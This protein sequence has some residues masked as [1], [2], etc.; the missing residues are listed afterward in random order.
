MTS[1]LPT[2]V[3]F[4]DEY[5]RPVFQMGPFDAAALAE[6]FEIIRSRTDPLSLDWETWFGPAGVFTMT[7]NGR[8]AIDLTLEDLDLAPD[9][10]IL[11]VTTSGGPYVSRCVTDSIARRCR[12]SR[13]LGP[14]TRAIFMI[15]E[16]G[17]P[18]AL[19]A[20]LVDSGLPII[21][22]CAY[23]FGSTAPEGPTGRL[24]DYVIFSFSKSMPL[25]YGGL[26]KSRHRLR[27]GSTLSGR[28]QRETPILLEHHLA[29]IPAAVERRRA[30]YELYRERF[31]EEG[32]RPLFDLKPGVAPHSFLVFLPDEA[33]AAAMRPRLHGAGVI[34]SV[35]YGGG[36]YF[37]PNHQRLSEAAVDYIVTHFVAALREC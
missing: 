30:V 29:A 4:A 2:E 1:L 28:A 33:K 17:F 11:I 9:D 36:G 16:F 20:E 37:L 27:S 3:L 14:M 7:R 5:N 15:H 32:L 26:L 23:A 35:F 22:D 34:S 13:R 21:E 18:A 31:A 6:N 8:E 24:G 25:P 12:W 19:P 10:E